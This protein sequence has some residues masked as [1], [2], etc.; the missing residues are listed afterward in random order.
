MKPFD[1]T[2]SKKG[3]RAF[4]RSVYRAI[5]S[6]RRS[7]LNTSVALDFV[8]SMAGYMWPDRALI[9]GA[10]RQLARG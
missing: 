9:N 8:A 5:R 4:G 1:N 10:V 7:T 3:N 2:L 6:A